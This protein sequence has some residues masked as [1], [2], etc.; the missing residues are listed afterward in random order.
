MFFARECYSRAIEKAELENKEIDIILKTHDVKA[1]QYRS[2][3]KMI[4]FG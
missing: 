2:I 1:N 3:I 4:Q